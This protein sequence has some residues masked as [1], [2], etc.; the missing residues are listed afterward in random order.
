VTKGLSPTEVNALINPSPERQKMAFKT[1]LLPESHD[2]LDHISI[3]K[4]RNGSGT[5]RGNAHSTHSS[6][7]GSTSNARQA[8]ESS[9]TRP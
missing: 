8:L 9:G 4:S 5:I 7:R 6:A 3:D 1:H 2:I